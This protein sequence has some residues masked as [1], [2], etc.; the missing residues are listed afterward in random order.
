MEVQLKI[1]ALTEGFEAFK[2]AQSDLAAVNAEVSK[3][4]KSTGTNELAKTYEALGAD[5]RAAYK[6]LRLV[7]DA[8]VK[9]KIDSI[10]SA[11]D[12]LAASGQATDA[13]LQRAQASME[14]QIGTL[15]RY[16]QAANDADGGM[17]TK[18]AEGAQAAVQGLT[19]VL[20]T[21][22]NAVTQHSEAVGSS[23]VGLGLLAKKTGL[24]FGSDLGKAIGTPFAMGG[25]AIA[26]MGL[27]LL[28]WTGYVYL[29]IAAIKTLVGIFT[30]DAFK[31]ETIDTLSKQLDGFEKIGNQLGINATKAQTLAAAFERLKVAQVPVSQ[32][33]YLKAGNDLS[34]LAK[35]DPEGAAAFDKLGVQNAAMLTQQQLIEAT[36]VALGKYTSEKERQAAADTVGI[37]NAEN[38]IAMT[39]AVRGELQASEDELRQYNIL[40]GQDGADAFKAYE[41]AVAEF[42]RNGSLTTQGFKQVI[43]DALMPVLTDL[44]VFF[45][46]GMP[47]AVAVFR[48]VISTAVSIF[49]SFMLGIYTIT[50][51][52][53]GA[54]KAAGEAISGLGK[55]MA[56][57]MVGDFNGAWAAIKEGGNQAS[58]QLGK[59][60]DNI[61][62]K[63]TETNKKIRLA[64]D[65]G[66]TGGDAKA[67]PKAG[68][69]TRAVEKTTSPAKSSALG[70]EN[71]LEAARFAAL[72]LQL[73]A[74]IKLV[75]DAL[76]REQRELDTAFAEG[77][78]SIKDYYAKRAS[79][80]QAGIDAEIALKEKE[81]AAAKKAEAAAGTDEKKK[82]QLSGQ[83]AQLEADLTILQRKRA[84]I[85]VET[86]R[87]TKKA[88]DEYA[89]SIDDLKIKLTELTGVEQRTASE[90]RAALT[91]QYEL[92]LKKAQAEDLASGT[93]TQKAD[94]VTKVV[95]LE[96]VKADFAVV[97]REY[98][99]MLADMQTALKEV[100]L[101]PSL[102]TIERIAKQDSVRAAAT[103]SLESKRQELQTLI[104][105]SQA[106]LN[107]SDADVTAL[108]DKTKVLGQ[109]IQGLKPKV[110]DLGT[111]MRDT[112]QNAIGNELAAVITK[113]KTAKE[114]MIDLAKTML[115][116][117]AKVASQNFMK[118]IFG[119][120]GGGYGGSSGG[121]GTNWGAM[122]ASWFGY[123]DGGHVQGAG[124]GTSDSIP[125]M[126]SNGEFVQ[127]ANAVQHYGVDFMEAIR[128]LKFPKL[129]VGMLPKFA[130]GGL[131]GLQSQQVLQR[132][133]K[134]GQVSTQRVAQAQRFATGG[135]VQANQAAVDAAATPN[136]TVNIVNNGTPQRS[137]DQS[138]DVKSQV[139][140]VFMEDMKVN[141]P[142]AQAV[143]GVTGTQRRR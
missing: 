38:Y 95:N 78:T 62:A 124:T 33:N 117:F 9:A 121:S 108:T 77:L 125:A 139:L 3:T 43:A 4:P 32:D 132:F 10:R 15:E 8:E 56:R 37:V 60:F 34:T 102:T 115:A 58:N 6:E 64:V 11:Y 127:T 24:S 110:V 105:Q 28:K 92:Q 136:I 14:S 40:V 134:G 70:V 98:Q 79:I 65:G 35:R 112:F 45:K 86:E 54:I 130:K 25:A 126:L 99:K 59:S 113:T 135:F 69:L 93:G 53:L 128:S 71:D 131:V 89:K 20:G 81:I 104:E 106:T 133:A 47:N 83:R 90:R 114:A 51:S 63:A 22:Y 16:G 27:V 44:A 100:D 118:Q 36:A 74:Q 66:G 87:S 30:G 31:N 111:A 50:E 85:A 52:I 123:A 143:N 61:A 21:S 75:R 23:L 26:D 116:E 67:R 72:K 80:T 137:T 122:I 97:E 94:L 141:G 19:D 76:G 120:S 140:S 1:K 57:A 101:D 88:T 82:L 142:M 46:E 42:S 73:E 2:K 17:G 107:L 119:G 96:A 48:T 129:D 55:A 29:G 13:E 103:I 5:V 7:P 68:D 91:A 18:I 138:F 109:E 39:A 49:H 84:D 12:T 41:T